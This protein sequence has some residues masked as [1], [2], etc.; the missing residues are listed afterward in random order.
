MLLMKVQC[1]WGGCCATDEGAVLLQKL[2][3]YLLQR[4]VLLERVPCY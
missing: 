4:G 2:L 3:C 1:Y